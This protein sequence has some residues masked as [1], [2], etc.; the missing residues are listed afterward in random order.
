MT[1]NGEMAVILRYFTEFGS[2]W[3]A[4][5]PTITNIESWRQRTALI[6][7]RQNLHF[8]AYSRRTMASFAFSKPT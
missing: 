1:L 4:A 2:F 6:F 3:G 7:E 8:C 5:L